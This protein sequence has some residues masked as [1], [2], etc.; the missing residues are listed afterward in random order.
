M[1]NWLARLVDRSK[2]LDGRATYGHMISLKHTPNL[3]LRVKVYAFTIAVYPV[4]LRADKPYLCYR[5][6]KTSPN[7]KNRRKKKKQ[8]AQP[9]TKLSGEMS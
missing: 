1:T 7:K 2:G 8:R 4:I 3:H 9:V 5:L 6:K